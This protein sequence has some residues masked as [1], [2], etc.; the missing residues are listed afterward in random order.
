MPKKPT[1][2]ELWELVA[3]DKADEVQAILDE[4]PEC[5]DMEDEDG[6]TLL[7]YVANNDKRLRVLKILIDYKAAVG[8][9]DN[10]GDT[11]LHNAAYYG[12]VTAAQF[13]LNHGADPNIKNKYGETPADRARG[14]N[15][16][17]VAEMI[18]VRS[19][20]TP[21]PHTHTPTPTP[22]P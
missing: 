20:S 9:Q 4:H 16:T 19:R 6:W 21:P 2:D 8:K 15:K 3:G 12:S 11:P 22:R 10:N 1:F 13:L 17:E 14:R 18:E 7:H 5:V